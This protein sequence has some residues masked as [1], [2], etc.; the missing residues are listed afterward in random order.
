MENVMDLTK[1]EWEK[2]RLLKKR[3]AYERKLETTIDPDDDEFD[4]ILDLIERLNKDAL[5]IQ[6][7]IEKLRYS[8][9]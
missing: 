2:Y 7:Q 8:R 4:R 3:D 9:K 1:L 6:L 5:K